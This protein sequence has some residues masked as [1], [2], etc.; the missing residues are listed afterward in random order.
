MNEKKF[1]ILINKILI[2][3]IPLVLTQTITN[4]IQ[5]HL[6]FYG[7][8][9]N[10]TA[11]TIALLM[12]TE[13]YDSKND[14][15]LYRIYSDKKFFEFLEFVIIALIPMLISYI[16]KFTPNPTHMNIISKAILLLTQITLYI[17]GLSL[18]I[19]MLTSRYLIPALEKS[20]EK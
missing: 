10:M 1:N 3:S 9:Y 11:A 6:T 15:K 20:A 2:Y 18:L 16:P 8:D 5:H 19:Y 14:L 12:A 7:S 4:I 17:L 13:I